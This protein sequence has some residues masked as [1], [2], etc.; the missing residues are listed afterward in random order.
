[1]S[2]CCSPGASG[3]VGQLKRGNKVTMIASTS[4]YHLVKPYNDH[5]GDVTIVTVLQLCCSQ[6]CV[7][8]SV[9]FARLMSIPAMV[10]SF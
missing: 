8:K 3:G 5:D 9:T 4:N 1:M 2:C 6:T 7:S 10:S